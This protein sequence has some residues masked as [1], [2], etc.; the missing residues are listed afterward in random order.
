[1]VAVVVVVV[2]YRGCVCSVFAPV[3]GGEGACC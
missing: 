2:G 1:M 3:C